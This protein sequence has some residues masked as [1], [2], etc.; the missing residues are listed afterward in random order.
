MT[1][2]RMEYTELEQDLLKEL[3]RIDEAIGYEL[4]TELGLKYDQRVEAIK[5][6]KKQLE[7]FETDI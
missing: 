2:V 7:D 1:K 3:S 5:Y 4:F 6:L